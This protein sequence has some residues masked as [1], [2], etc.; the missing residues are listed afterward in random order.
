MLQNTMSVIF[1]NAV[2]CHLLLPLDVRHCY[3]TLL[4]FRFQFRK[5]SKNKG[6]KLVS[7]EEW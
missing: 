3:K 6:L 1:L 7:R 4:Q 5:Q 2:Q